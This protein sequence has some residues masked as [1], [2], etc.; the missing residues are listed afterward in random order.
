VRAWAPVGQE[1]PVISS[2]NAVYVAPE[3]GGCD[4]AYEGGGY[5][6]ANLNTSVGY[7][8]RVITITGTSVDGQTFNVY[9][10]RGGGGKG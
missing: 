6:Y 1:M 8:R 3:D 7:D 4:K 10:S 9:L 2:A 5:Y